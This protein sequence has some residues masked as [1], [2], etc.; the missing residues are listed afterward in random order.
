MKK[1][2]LVV[3]GGMDSATLAY[4]YFKEGYKLHLVGFNYGQRHVKELLALQNLAG[5]LQASHEIVDLTG[6]KSSIAS[7]SL[8]S[9]EI[10]VPDG[11]YAEETMRITVVPNRNAI[12]LAIAT[13]IAVANGSDLVATGVHAGDHFIYPDCRPDFIEAINQA[14]I[15]GTRGHA[16]E[17]FRVE[18]PFVK[19]TKADIAKLGHSY[20]VPYQLTWSCYKGGDLHCGRCGT[21]VERIEAFIDAGVSDPTIYEDGIEFALAEIEKAKNA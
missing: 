21:C 2:T 15:L 12:M 6:L 4:H 11:H 20:Q 14:F 13:G 9:D 3:S 16:K 18:A 19:I 7:S 5:V 8:T 17:G 1:A 10:S